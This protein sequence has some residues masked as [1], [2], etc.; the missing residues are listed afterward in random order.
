MP[1]ILSFFGLVF[2]R[3]RAGILSRLL[4]PCVVRD[5]SDFERIFRDALY[6]CVETAKASDLVVFLPSFMA[7]NTR[8][9][10]AAHL[11][12]RSAQRHHRLHW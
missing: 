7:N 5:L 11:S 12:A 10:A 8:I 4:L 6:W 1:S 3:Y 2:T 9:A